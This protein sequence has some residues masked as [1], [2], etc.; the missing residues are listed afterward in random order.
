MVIIHPKVLHGG[1]M[2]TS[3]ALRR[4]LVLQAGDAMVPLQSVPEPEAVA[5]YKMTAG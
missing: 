2:N 5:G 4:N 1:S 3:Y